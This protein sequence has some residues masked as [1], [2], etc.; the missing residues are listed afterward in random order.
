M[1]DLSR[2]VEELVTIAGKRLKFDLQPHEVA[3]L[4]RTLVIQLGEE[5]AIGPEKMWAVEIPDNP[6]ALRD[7]GGINDYRYLLCSVQ[8]NFRSKLTNVDAA[9]RSDLQTT[10]A[11]IFHAIRG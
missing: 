1:T 5:V 8:V 11:L 10:I 4:Q 6:A 7:F 9:R 3:L 2:S